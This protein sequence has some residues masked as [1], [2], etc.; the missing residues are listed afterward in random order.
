MNESEKRNKRLKIHV[1]QE[2]KDAIDKKF[3]NSRFRSESEFIRVMILTDVILHFDKEQMKKLII[4]SSS[5]SNN[6]NQ[7]ARRVNSTGNIYSEDLAEIKEQQSRILHQLLKLRGEI[8]IVKDLV[9]SS[10]HNTGDKRM[11]HSIRHDTECIG[12]IN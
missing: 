7:I 5:A 12:S 10:C 8:H 1:S 3:I 4:D 11:I 2:E 9:G 6:I